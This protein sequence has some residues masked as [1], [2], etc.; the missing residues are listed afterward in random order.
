MK[1]HQLAQCPPP[2][3]SPRAS[4]FEAVKVMARA[5]VGAAAVVDGKKLVGV[6]SERDVMLR[7]VAKQKDPAATKVRQVM[8]KAVKTVQP[9]CG[10]DE[11]ISI[12]VANHIRHVVIV[13]E[14]GHV[15]GLASSREVFQS[16]LES[17]D[18]TVRTLEAFACT[19]TL[20][21]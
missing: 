9:E 1:V 18:D 7:V 8:T 6:I 19:D 17:L 2:A 14:R 3:V 10:T 13:N 20:G 4:V 5:G 11:A 21:G 16:H 15:V 12:M